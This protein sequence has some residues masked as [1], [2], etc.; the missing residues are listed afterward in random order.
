[1]VVA[2][3]MITVGA[4]EH[5]SWMNT[6]KENIQKVP[7]VVEVH[8]VMGRYDIIAKV[9][10]KTW[11]ELVDLVGDKIRSISGVETTETF[12]GYE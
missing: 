4:G 10:L 3:I 12:V 9:E 8:C 5:L 1:M 2:Y 6:V 11:E 7:G